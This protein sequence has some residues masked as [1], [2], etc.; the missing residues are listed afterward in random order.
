[1]KN[2]KHTVAVSVCSG[3]FRLQ[4]TVV[5]LAPVS[6]SSRTV[7]AHGNRHTSFVWKSSTDITPFTAKCNNVCPSRNF[8]FNLCSPYTSWLALFRSSIVTLAVSIFSTLVR[9]VQ[10]YSAVIIFISNSSITVSESS[11]GPGVR[12]LL[13]FTFSSL[14]HAFKT[15]N[16]YAMKETIFQCQI[17]RDSHKL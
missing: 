11:F 2:I 3:V 6:N 12:I 5:A 14:V 1:M 9:I 4:S 15:A 16:I 10:R 8:K 13:L 7:S 17:Q